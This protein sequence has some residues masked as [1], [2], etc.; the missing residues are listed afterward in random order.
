MASAFGMSATQPILGWLYYRT[1][2]YRVHLTMTAGKLKNR[3]NLLMKLAG[4]TWGA[5]TNTLLWHFAISS[6][7]LHPSLVMLC[8]HKSG[9]CAV[10]LYHASH[11]WYPL[12]YTSPM[13]SSAL[14]HWTASPTKKG[15]HWQLVEKIVR[16]DS[17]LI[18]PDILSPPLLQLTSR[19]PLWLDLQPVDIKSRWSHN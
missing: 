12:F 10:E 15:C 11:L 16:H 7:V 19:K 6:R 5:S 3:N 13:A 8:S 9:R 4:S 18:Q 14:Q 1:L 2:S 17:W